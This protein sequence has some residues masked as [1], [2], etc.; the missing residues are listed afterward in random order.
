MEISSGRRSSESHPSE[1]I[2]AFVRVRPPISSEISHENCIQVPTT[3]D[4]QLKSEKYEIKCKY[5]FV[6]NE[7][8]TQE[9]VFKQISPLLDD[10][11]LGYNASIFAYGQTSAGKVPPTFFF[12]SNS[13]LTDTY[14]AR[15]KWWTRP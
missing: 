9:E 11:L 5:D 10:V 1:A 13:L 6:F 15:S 8:S 2:K 7:L 4:I 12:V 14:Y 3:N